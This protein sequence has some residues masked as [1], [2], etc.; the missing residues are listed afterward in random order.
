MDITKIKKQ[1]DQEEILHE[2][3]FKI[4]EDTL[5]ILNEMQ[6]LE[7]EIISKW[8]DRINNKSV[9]FFNEF[10]NYFIENGFS[11]WEDEYKIEATYK[12]VLFQLYPKNYEGENITLEINNDYSFDFNIQPSTIA[13]YYNIIVDGIR[14]KDYSND[15]QYFINQFSTV[16]QLTELNEKI[17]S[18]LNYLN[19]ALNSFDKT[20]LVIRKF[21]DKRQ[22]KSFKELIESVEIK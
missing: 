12:N 1:A 4:K 15:P 19:N 22:Y 6:K 9:E 8:N 20:E 5:E 16:E 14:F 7:V 3:L 13:P 11:I 10:K 18:N 2:K 21:N 17:Q